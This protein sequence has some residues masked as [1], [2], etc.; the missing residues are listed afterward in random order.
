MV[1]VTIREKKIL[2][3]CHVKFQAFSLAPNRKKLQNE[4]IWKHCSYLEFRVL[5]GEDVPETQAKMATVLSGKT[6]VCLG[7]K[8]FINPQV[9][10]SRLCIYMIIS[11][12]ILNQ[13]F[14]GKHPRR[15]QSSKSQTNASGIPSLCF[16]LCIS[17]HNNSLSSC[18]CSLK[19]RLIDALLR[20]PKWSSPAT[21]AAEPSRGDEIG[22]L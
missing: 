21:L 1:L 15:V 7:I 6:L 16:F 18:C 3:S 12:F 13:T 10:C 22:S 9:Y 17:N 8:C 19:S 4:I 11:L 14:I 2:K 20:L 5:R